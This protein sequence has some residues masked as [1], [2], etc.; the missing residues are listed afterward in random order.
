MSKQKKKIV[1]FGGNTGGKRASKN[2]GLAYL[3]V[4]GKKLDHNYLM[5]MFSVSETILKHTS[6]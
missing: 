2:S 5:I 1:L 6:D 4:N 3:K